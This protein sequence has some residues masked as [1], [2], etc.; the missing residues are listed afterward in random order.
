ML[1]TVTSFTEHYQ[2]LDCKIVYVG[3]EWLYVV[4]FDLHL[5]KDGIF[6]VIMCNFTMHSGI[7]SKLDCLDSW[8]LEYSMFVG[9]CTFLY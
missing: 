7:V 2:F 9:K 8:L 5:D 6:S 4:Y 1:D 3:V